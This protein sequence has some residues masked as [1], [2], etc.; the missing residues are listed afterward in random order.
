MG[1]SYTDRYERTHVR[2]VTEG[3]WPMVAEPGP[4]FRWGVVLRKSKLKR[5]M[6]QYG[7]IALVAESLDHHELEVVSH[8]RNN[9][10]GIIV[11]TYKDIASGW[12]PKA[13]RPRYKHA[14]VD[15]S[16][17]WIDGI[18]VLAIDRLTRRTDQVR[19]ILNALEEMGGRLFALWDELDTA[20][21]DPEHNTELR[22]HELV[23]RAEREARRTSKRYKML[24]QHRARKGLHHP[25]NFRSYG[26]AR[27]CRSLVDEEAEMLFQAAKAVDQGKAVWAIVEE[28]TRRGV[29]T[30]GGGDH[31][32]SKVLR[33]IL[34]S[35]RMVGKREYEG[36]LIDIEYM[37][38]ILPEELWRRVRRRLL[39]NPPKRGPGESREL[40]NIALC[41]IC[42]LPLTSGLDKGSPVY[43]CKKRTSQP[44]ACGGIV[45]LVSR[46][47]AKV[48]EE[49]V[50]FLN[51]KQRAQALL[52]QHRLETPEIA[53]IDARYAELEDNKL[54]L[55]RAAF[56]P[57][58]GVR[59]L[60]TERYWEFRAEIEREKE[61][62]QRRR[63][64]NRDA[65]PLREA[66]HEEWTVEDWRSRPLEWRRA[67]ISLVVE[68][69]E[70]ARTT[71]RGAARGHLGAVH[72]P[73]RVKVK[74]VG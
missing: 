55:E 42:D 52:D 30:V 41:G 21:N 47:D 58:Q 4:N 45:I 36:A 19:P 71:R 3:L 74:L 40:T 44:G 72:Y 16:S 11:E 29:P 24:A 1:S 31:W 8:I 63:I 49:V 22:L 68:R 28:W 13:K 65:Q 57:P 14:L 53:A 2:R 18:A 43:L 60:P 64:V 66:L 12:N 5:T 33:R 54:A 69:I 62:L 67:V 6:N 61:T 26:H 34:V 15:L 46:L 59:K 38:P 20:Y 35:P 23:E 39:E 73:D 56:N 25:G 27:D 17:G 9:N 7:E 48:N 70:V 10:M 51:D 37:P 50:A 32:H